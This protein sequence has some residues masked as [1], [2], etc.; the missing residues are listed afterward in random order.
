[1]GIPVAIADDRSLQNVDWELDL[2]VDTCPIACKKEV[3]KIYCN[4]GKY[5][6]QANVS[7]DVQQELV[8]LLGITKRCSELTNYCDCIKDSHLAACALTKNKP[9]IILA[10]GIMCNIE[11]QIMKRVRPYSWLIFIS[12][13]SPFAVVTIGLITSFFFAMLLYAAIYIFYILP[14]FTVPDL[15]SKGGTNLAY[16]IIF[17]FIGS[18]TS[19]TLRTGSYANLRHI[20]LVLLFWTAFSKPFLGVIFSMMIF[21]MFNATMVTATDNKTS[22]NILYFWVV[23]GFL[24]GFSERFATDLISRAEAAVLATSNGKLGAMT[25]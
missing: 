2:E 8:R 20:D 23:A 14:G 22:D 16:T 6:Q 24:S 13:A 10:Q 17:S 21:F 19:I 9:D 18:M 25:R 11:V 5:I 3:L 7:D 15:L 1:V 12:K 4:I